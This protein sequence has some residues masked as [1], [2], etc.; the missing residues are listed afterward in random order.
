M[1]IETVRVHGPLSR[2]DLARITGL[3]VQTISNIAEELIAA[4]LLLETPVSTGM[5]GKPPKLLTINPDGAYSIGLQLDHNWLIGVLLDITGVRRGEIVVQVDSPAP[6]AGLVAL[7][8]AARNLAVGANIQLE[9]I[10]GV[11][12]VMPGP[13][14]VDPIANNGPTVLPGWADVAVA[15]RLAERLNLPVSLENDATAAAMGEHYFGVARQHRN[16][17]V[18]FVGTGLG[19]GVLVNGQPYRGAFGNAGEIGHMSVYP[20]GRRCYC[21]NQGCAETYLSVHAAYEHLGY[22][23]TPPAYDELVD[24]FRTGERQFDTWMNKAA[25]VLRLLVVNLENLF[26]PE[27]VIV[28]GFMPHPILAE[29]QRRALPLPSSVASRR[30]REVPRLILGA[31]GQKVAAL[32]AAVLPLF[33]S[34][35]HLTHVSAA[36]PVKR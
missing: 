6:Q 32:G 4:S 9:Q 5:R 2:A 28:N 24:R 15:D 29:L 13:F 36:I 22:A 8:K 35:G 34:F 31:A 23:R 10:C 18:I 20:E 12:V 25:I 16:I 26:D 14:E 27:A 21:G 7:E 3:S 11:S 1:A 17:V 30:R 19:G 33:Y